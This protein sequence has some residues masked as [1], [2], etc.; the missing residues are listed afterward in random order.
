MAIDY[1][2]FLHYDRQHIV[3]RYIATHPAYV[4]SPDPDDNL[5]RLATDIHHIEWRVTKENYPTWDAAMADWGQPAPGPGPGP[6]E[7]PPVVGRQGRVRLDGRSYL[8]DTGDFSPL[9]GT[10]FWAIRGWKFERDRVKQN[11]AYLGSHH[12]DYMRILGDVGWAGNEVD[13]TWHDYVPLLGELIDWAYDQQG[14][15]TQVTCWGGS[16]RNPLGVAHRVVEAVTGREHKV[17]FLEAANESFNNG[18]DEATVREMVRILAATGI[19]TAPSSPMPVDEA[20]MAALMPDASLAPVHLD[21]AYG[22]LN[23]RFV[24]QPWDVK[25]FP[26]ATAQNEPCGPQSSVNAC[27]QPCQLTMSRA[28][29]ILC[30][31][32]AYVLHNAAGVSGQVDPN[33]HHPRP[34][35]LW[36]MPGIDPIM[37]SLRSLDAFL[38]RMEGWI[39][40]NN[41]WSAPNPQNPMDCSYLWQDGDGR[42]DGAN[43]NYSA[44]FPRLDGSPGQFVTLPSGIRAGGAAFT[45]RWPSTVKVYKVSSDGVIRLHVEGPLGAGAGMHLPGSDDSFTGYIVTGLRT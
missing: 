40:A 33:P 20:T 19:I 9:G 17:I 30:G 7:P 24:R 35:N 34:A 16:N 22:D 43:K 39:P 14:I 3:N 42:T 5:R 13:S 31:A 26:W 10:L 38:P 44:Q 36:E 45:A 41:G 1:G 29:G 28:V 23:W 32:G 4:P 25:T 15:R 6:I 27:S 18:P 37:Q 8:D 12:W 11:I 21:R 2:N